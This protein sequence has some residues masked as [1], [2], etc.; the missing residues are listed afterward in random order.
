ME[1]LRKVAR[2]FAETAESFQEVDL[3]RRIAECHW[4]AAQVY[5]VL[6]EHMKAR[7]QH[8]RRAFHGMKKRARCDRAFLNKRAV[9]K[10]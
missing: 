4:K 2:S 5:D 3:K 10:D 8:A 9:F 6:D 1:H 7:A